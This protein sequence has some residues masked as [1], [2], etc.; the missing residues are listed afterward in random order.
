MHGRRRCS[1]L[2]CKIAYHLEH[3]HAD[4]ELVL[5]AVAAAGPRLQLHLVDGHLRW[6]WLGESNSNERCGTEK[7]STW[8]TQ[9]PSCTYAGSRQEGRLTRAV[10]WILEIQEMA[11]KGGEVKAGEERESS[12]R[13]T[14]AERERGRSRDRPPRHALLSVPPSSPSSS[15]S[16]ALAVTSPRH[17]ACEHQPSSAL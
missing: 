1:R 11:G 7:P 17:I 5:G 6:L 3:A 4:G 10:V 13:R 15:T 9:G 12:T 16:A 14:Q 8:I 2:C